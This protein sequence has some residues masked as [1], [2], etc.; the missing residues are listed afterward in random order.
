[1]SEELVG[2]VEQVI[3]GGVAYGVWCL[4]RVVGE[5]QDRSE[6]DL[7]WRREIEDASQLGGEKLVE[8]LSAV[9]DRDSERNMVS[10]KS[11]H[12]YAPLIL[13]CL[14]LVTCC[15]DCMLNLP[16]VSTTLAVFSI[17][18]LVEGV[19][20]AYRLKRASFLT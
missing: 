8:S 20:G 11:W 19:I 13:G 5:K 17:I 7:I 2:Q 6:S 1:M 14:G 16:D 12:V 15:A 9:A 18:E 10:Y 4:L 3:A